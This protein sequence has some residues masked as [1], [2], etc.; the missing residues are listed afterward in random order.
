MPATTEPPT[1][2]EAAAEMPPPDPIDLWPSPTPFDPVAEAERLVWVDPQRVGGVPCFRNTR[3]P[4][5]LLFDYLR[6]CDGNPLEEFYEAYEMPIPTLRRVIDLAAR[7]VL[8]PLDPWPSSE[9]PEVD[10]Q[11]AGR[12]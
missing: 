10:E 9:A 6:T 8:P 4:V 5:R 12:G 3:L 11:P 7:G 2:S 1:A